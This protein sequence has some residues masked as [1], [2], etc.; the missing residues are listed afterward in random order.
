MF[1]TDEHKSEYLAPEDEWLAFV[2]G[3]T[4]SAGHAVITAG[5]KGSKAKA[6]LWTDCRYYEQASRELP[7]GWKVSKTDSS[8]WRMADFLR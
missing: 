6:M 7:A 3:F 5:S 4:G 2:S 8:L 1:R